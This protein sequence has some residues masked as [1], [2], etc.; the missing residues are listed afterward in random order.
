MNNFNTINP[1]RQECSNLLNDAEKLGVRFPPKEFKSVHLG[2]INWTVE[3]IA[4][5]LKVKPDSVRKTLRRAELRVAKKTR[6]D[7]A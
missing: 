1:L 3:D 6:V 4:Q 5:N 2:A 7:L